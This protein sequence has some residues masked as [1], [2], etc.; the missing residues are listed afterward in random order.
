[1]Y[2]L[3]SWTLF[4][5]S[6]FLLCKC[7]SFHALWHFH[8]SYKNQ[9]LL[10]SRLKKNPKQPESVFIVTSISDWLMFM[11]FLNLNCP[12]LGS[13]NGTKGPAHR[14]PLH[15]MPLHWRDCHWQ[16]RVRHASNLHL[17]CFGARLTF[18]ASIAM[19]AASALG[20]WAGKWKTV[21]E[22]CSKFWP[23]CM[24]C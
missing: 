16:H 7:W 10:Y 14:Y 24:N 6:F 8:F 1:M 5:W 22:Q 13:R 23:A 9:T 15:M 18:P 21:L 20:D 4:Y 11:T 2:L 19:K 17:L 3:K 12:R